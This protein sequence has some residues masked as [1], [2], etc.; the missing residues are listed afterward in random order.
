MGQPSVALA[1][2]VLACAEGALVLFILRPLIDDG[3]L[4]PAERNFVPLALD[5]I[6]PNFR[7]DPFEEPAHVAH[8]RVVAQDGVTLLTEIPDTKKAQTEKW[9]KS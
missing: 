6:L 8:D 7:P 5:E 4:L 2:D 1:I 9:H 3:A